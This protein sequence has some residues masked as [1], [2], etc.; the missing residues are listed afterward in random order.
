MVAEK[1]DASD[2]ERVAAI[3]GD[4]AGA[5]EMFALKALMTSVGTP[6]IDCRQDGT[7]LSPEY[8]RE[9]YLFN[10]TI[11][12]IDQ[13]DAVLIIGANP[14]HEASVLNARI[15]GAWRRNAVKIGLIGVPVDLTY[16]YDYLGAGPDTLSQLAAGEHPFSEILKTARRPVVLVGQGA[17]ARPDGDVVL[18][19]A[20]GIAVAG[21]RDEGWNGLAVLHTAAARVGGLD[22]GFVP[23]EGGHDVIGMVAAA[24]AGEL[25]VMV[26]LGADEI[27]VDALGETFIVYVGSHGDVGAH[28]A[29]VILPGATYAEKSTTYVNT[30]GRPQ[31]TARAAFPP[32]EAREDWA[33]LRALSGVVGH[34]LPFDTLA[35]LRA[36]MYQEHPHLA[37]IDQV[38]DGSLTTVTTLARSEGNP[39][40][41]GFDLAVQD[42]YLTNPITR[43]SAVMAE[44]SALAAS[45]MASA[46]E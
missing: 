20:A 36:A 37:R 15:R 41:D 40:S 8:G 22:V 7:K 46:A 12:G 38:E 33:I 2:P 29:D 19:L 18:S 44:C 23:G 31:M 27:A 1:I 16:P 24:A 6:H 39:S 43:A 30:E 13:A 21:E 17:L 10:P 32:G 14:R 35:A 28:R 42:F 4:L 5:E 34:T 9:S 11:A 25:D 45:R 3:A 26:L